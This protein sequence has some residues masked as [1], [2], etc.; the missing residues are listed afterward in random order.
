MTTHNVTAQS[1]HTDILVYDIRDSRYVN[2]CDRCTLVCQFCP[3]TLNSKEVHEFDLSLHQRHEAEA[4]IDAIGDPRAFDE[5]VFCGFGEPTLRLKPLLLI[6]K[7]IK[8]KGG[9]V[10]VNTDGLGNRFHKRNILPELAECIDALS[11]SMNAHTDA[12]YQQHCQPQL[13]GSFQHML[14]FIE[15]APHYIE[16]VTTT[17]I[18]G[19]EGVDIAA[20]RQLATDRNVKF[21]ERHLDVVG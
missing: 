12:L 6:A 9:R 17:A 5:I 8:Q 14:D 15:Q 7:N 13:T 1:P 10:R 11:I 18:N 3:K 16:D 19:L 21:R 2:L 20:C 4:Y